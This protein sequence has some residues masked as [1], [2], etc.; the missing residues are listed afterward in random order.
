MPRHRVRLEDRK[1]SVRAC[2]ACRLS[3][4]RCDSRLPCSS[5]SRKG[6]GASCVY[7]D[8]AK[9]SPPNRIGSARDREGL[10]IHHEPRSEDAPQPLLAQNARMLLTAKGEKVY[11]GK[12]AAISM[13]QFLRNVLRRYAGPSTFTESRRSN[14]M[15]EATLR[16]ASHR[17]TDFVDNLDLSERTELIHYY[18]VASNGFLNLL[19]DGILSQLNSESIATP[20]FEE[21]SL[22]DDITAAY[23]VIAIGA[24]CR[25]NGDKDVKTS[26]NYFAEAQRLGFQDMLLNPSLSMVRN[27]I[28]MAFYMFCACRRNTGLLYLGVASRAATILGLH[29]PELN[30]TLPADIRTAR[31]QI[32]KSLRVLDLITNS[33]LGRP[34]G[35]Q[36]IQP[37][38]Q[39]AREKSDLLPH[40]SMTLDAMFE[41]C[42]IVELIAQ[43][44]TR[45]GT[46]DIPTTEEFLQKLRGWAQ[47]LPPTLRQ[48][49]T[50]GND[51][52]VED[53]HQQ[54]AIGNI[55]VACNYYFGVMLA[56]RQFL[57]S[58]AITWLQQKQANRNEG[59]SFTPSPSVAKAQELARVCTDSA[60]Y[61]VQM[62]HDAGTSDFLLGNMCI[63][64]AWVFA[65]GLILGL[66][67]LRPPEIT[68]SESHFYFSSS[69]NVLK[70][71]AKLSPQ[72]QRYAEILSDLSRAIEGYHRQLQKDSSSNNILLERILK[73]TTPNESGNNTTGLPSPMI[74]HMGYSSTE[75]GDN[76]TIDLLDGMLMHEP[77]AIALSLQN[78]DDFGFNI[79]WDDYMSTAEPQEASFNGNFEQSSWRLN[80]L[81]TNLY[82]EGSGS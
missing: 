56:T 40:T 50:R 4:K 59:Q 21:T 42:S 18:K 5:C 22:K 52:C 19:T 61:L 75:E 62:C 63:L 34:S 25:G 43:K 79:L 60:T 17:P 35:T 1:R 20:E 29:L 11:V 23:L 2:E 67:L 14:S 78:T 33:I 82:Q 3:R 74:S 13:L 39:E 36:D 8:R 68:S 45:D 54:A 37:E 41:S 69:Q 71:I 30:A 15:L 51:G 49:L 12:T 6:I 76:P 81:T 27:F 73:P 16:S 70:R 80:D 66:S 28:L 65:A 26:S 64:Q 72:A 77:S 10:P 46:L 53:N 58:E 31:V 7:G 9:Q 55:H 57:I 38:A 32:W 24:H 47:G 48:L 44:I